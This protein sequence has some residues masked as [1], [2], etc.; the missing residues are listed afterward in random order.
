MKMKKPAKSDGIQY[1]KSRLVNKKTRRLASS[2]TS[3]IDLAACAISMGET[4][5]IATLLPLAKAKRLLAKNTLQ[6]FKPQKRSKAGNAVATSHTD[7][8]ALAEAGLPAIAVFYLEMVVGCKP[9][10]HVN[11]KGFRSWL[12]D[13]LAVPG[14]SLNRFLLSRRDLAALV[15]SRRSKR[16]W[17]DRLKMLKMQSKLHKSA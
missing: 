6:S 15:E 17:L 11:L 2:S 13:E 5:G 3:L 1:G 14:S 9:V 12:V 10:K 16:W 8:R 7:L 4:T